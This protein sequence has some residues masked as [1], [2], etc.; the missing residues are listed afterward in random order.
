MPK[1]FRDLGC[2][3]VRESVIYRFIPRTF[4]PFGNEGERRIIFCPSFQSHKG[5]SI[6]CVIFVVFL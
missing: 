1:F 2:F 6:H 5:F 4:F 3:F